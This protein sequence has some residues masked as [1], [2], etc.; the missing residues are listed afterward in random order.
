MPILRVLRVCIAA[1]GLWAAAGAVADSTGSGE[2]A[3]S[4]EPSCAERVADRIQQRYDAIRDIEARFEQRTRSVTLGGSSLGDDAPARGRVVIAKPG[5]M[6]WAYEEPAPSLVVS[7][8]Q[9]MWLYDPVAGEASK[10]AVDQGYLSGAA[11]Q[12]LMGEGRLRDAFEVSAETCAADG[13]APVEL[14]L[15]PREPTSYE[16]MRMRA[17]PRTG[18][19]LATEVVDVFGNV[20]SV[21]F[22]DVQV[23]RSPGDDVFRFDPPDD[24]TVVDLL[25]PP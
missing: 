5:R 7:D 16:R 11:L 19:I 3:E 24:V 20:T 1:L 4:A 14:E 17:D 13:E 9:V 12:F 8:G 18:D 22:Q 21:S 23:D 2:P 6:R 25:T 10:V 15:L